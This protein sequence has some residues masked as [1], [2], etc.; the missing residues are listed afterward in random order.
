[1]LKQEQRLESSLTKVPASLFQESDSMAPTW[2]LPSSAGGL[3][4]FRPALAWQSPWVWRG[5]TKQKAS[6]SV[7]VSSNPHS[8]SSVAEEE[9]L[10]MLFRTRNGGCLL[11]SRQ[12]SHGRINQS[13]EP[14]CLMPADMRE[15]G[16]LLR[17]TANTACSSNLLV[18]PVQ[19]RYRTVWV[20]NKI[21]EEKRWQ[22]CCLV[23]VA[24][25]AHDIHRWALWA[26]VGACGGRVGLQSWLQGS[27]LYRT[28]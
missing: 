25:R 19:G 3:R 13:A 16:F 18:N 23:H 24:Q 1:M 7:I 28:H 21:H 5:R 9:S 4:R 8:N 14:N 15:P 2:G 27:A 20:D 26:P 6:A 12:G 22:R 17:P 10:E 11:A